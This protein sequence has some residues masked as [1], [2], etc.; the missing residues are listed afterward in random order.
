[1]VAE[2]GTEGK[3]PLLDWVLERNPQTPRTRAK[4]WIRA[5]RVSVRGMVLRRPHQ[6]LADPGEGLELL[7]RQAAALE[8]GGGWQI[9]SRLALVHLDG[10]LAVVNKGAGLLSLPLA[11]RELSALS[12]LADFL[13]GRLKAK[14]PA[15]GARTLP[16]AYRRLQPLPVHRLDQYTSGLMC[17]ALNGV[18]RH[19][20]IEQLQ[21]RTM[22]RVYVAF[23]E[24]P[25]V[26]SQGTWRHWLKLTDD[27]LRQG[28][29]P[30]A[31]GKNGVR[32][33]KEAITHYEVL[34]QYAL[35]D[36]KS[37][38][39]KLRLRLETGRKHQI[40]VQAAH[41]G[42]PLIG[43]QWYNPR[44][45]PRTKPPIDFP[46]QALHAETLTLEHPEQPGRRLSWTAELPQDLKRLEANLVAGRL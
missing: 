13:A 30:E 41:S 24:G 18:A 29:L 43:D 4:Q 9:H 14:E 45:D 2:I 21:T 1:M 6:L 33:A 5:G 12:I 23:V 42:L 32:E 37:W 46:R 7:G 40:R 8:C 3:R 20:L 16:A 11:R 27:E 38:V 31:M 39:T 28:V 17:M 35:A 34:E 44:Y 22:K 25:P 26:A 15:F 19:A 10:S 36:G